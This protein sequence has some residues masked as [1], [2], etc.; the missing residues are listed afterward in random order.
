MKINFEEINKN[1]KMLSQSKDEKFNGEQPNAEKSNGNKSNDEKPNGDKSTDKPPA[2]QA[3]GPPADF[4]LNTLMFNRL[5]EYQVMNEVSRHKLC[6]PV[7]A[8]YQNGICYG[9]ADGVVVSGPLMLTSDF[10]TEMA[11]KLAEFH[12]IK[13]DM[14]TVGFETHFERMDR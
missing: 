13:F 8:K 4:D 11:T 3:A 1:M 5:I 7:Y 9:F 12:S 2:S 14:P 6:Q 10:E